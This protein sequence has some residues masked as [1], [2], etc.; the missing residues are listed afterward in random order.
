MLIEPKPSPRP[1]FA[2]WRRESGSFAQL[3]LI[4]RG[5]FAEILKLTD[6][7]GVIDIGER[8]PAEAIAWAL[9]ADRSD[10]RALA[11]YVPMLLADGCLVHEG[12]TLRAP[13][14]QRW[15]PTSKRTKPSNE[16]TTNGRDR[17]TTGPRT[18]TTEPRS[19]RDGAATASRSGHE[20]EAKSA[21]P[22][23]SGSHSR[24]EK[25]KE[26][27]EES[28]DT[29]S[30][31]A[32][33]PSATL[34]PPAPSSEPP[35]RGK[36]RSDVLEVFEYWRTTLGKPA[37]AKLDPKRRKRIEWA[38]GAYGL[39]AVKRCIDG[40]A[41]SAWHRGQNDRGRP[42]DDL[43]L[44][45]RDAERVERGLEMASSGGG[46]TGARLPPASIDSKSAAESRRRASEVL[47]PL[48]LLEVSNA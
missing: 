45:L 13:S 2:L 24:E 29:Q 8:S 10:R 37:S 33:P 40:Y 11:K 38:I 23:G 30:S 7:D 20:T 43:T 32:E 48:P 42:Y 5:L 22:L 46:R 31:P 3:P 14:F 15:Q 6:D 27:I 44:W 47:G 25:R 36:P 28:K 1:W 4:A 41:S 26:E 19:G 17:A 16:P 39:E 9:G 21:E 12:T 18:S 34:D 35:S